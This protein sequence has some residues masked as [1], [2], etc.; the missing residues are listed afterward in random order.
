MYEKFSACRET[1][2]QCSFFLFFLCKKGS[3]QRTDG[4]GGDDDDIYVVNVHE[5]VQGAE[6][7]G[8]EGGA[9]VAVLLRPDGDAELLGL[10]Q[11]V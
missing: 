10:L 1:M 6:R 7:G 9:G 8:I 2:V 4:G 5:S 3:R 11:K